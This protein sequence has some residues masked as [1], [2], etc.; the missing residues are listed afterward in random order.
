MRLANYIA[1]PM[2]EKLNNGHRLADFKL[3]IYVGVGSLTFY[4]MNLQATPNYAA[5]NIG[6]RY[7]K[8]DHISLLV[9]DNFFG[10]ADLILILSLLSVR[11][12]DQ[13]KAWQL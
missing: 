11:A 10:I 12:F 13:S 6:I 8:N 1:H 4:L 9:V 7:L 5:Q 3:K 2:T